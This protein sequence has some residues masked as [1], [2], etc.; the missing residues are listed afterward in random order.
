LRAA[1]EMFTAMGMAAFARRAARALVSTGE[2]LREH[3]AEVGNDLTTEEAQVVELVR[4]GLTDREIGARLFI[5]PR[6]V[7]WHLRNVYPKL[8]LRSRRELEARRP[9]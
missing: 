9:R 1:H 7:E 8:G 3:P 2:N 6:A 4:E 5:S